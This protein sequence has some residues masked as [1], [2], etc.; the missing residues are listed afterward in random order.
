VLTVEVPDIKSGRVAEIVMS[1][2]VVAALGRSAAKA[3][4]SMGQIH[5]GEGSHVIAALN[6]NATLFARVSIAGGGE[7]KERSAFTHIVKAKFSLTS[8][9]TTTTTS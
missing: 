2:P 7:G 1:G 5:D 3:L 6:L 8:S 4:F 9:T